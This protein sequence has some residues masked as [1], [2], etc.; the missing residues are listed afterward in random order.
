MKIIFL[1][2]YSP[3]FNPIELTFSVMMSWFRPS[4]EQVLEAWADITNLTCV[5]DLILTFVTYTI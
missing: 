3:K 1:P 4:Y 5:P 2:P